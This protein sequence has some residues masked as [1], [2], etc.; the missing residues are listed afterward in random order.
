MGGYRVYDDQYPYFITSGIT[1]GLPL[2]SNPAI[3]EIILENLNFLQEKRDV[4]IYSYVIM[5]NHLH[6]VIQGKDLA[7][8]VGR[9]KSFSAREIIDLMHEKR[10]TRWLKRLKKVMPINK[11]DRDFQFWESG[12]R[13][14]QMLSDEIMI[15]KI[16]YIHNNPVK[17]G[18][19]DKP[20]DWRYSSARNY[21][22]LP[23]LIPVTLFEI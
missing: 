2:F 1:F 13:P 19:V 23:G 12:Y 15:Q 5:E 22:G 4:K 18:Y 8:K 11:T 14:K 17:R 16:E 7:V 6:A 21:A 3:T 20:E 10:H 9:F